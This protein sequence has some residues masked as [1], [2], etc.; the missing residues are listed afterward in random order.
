MSADATDGRVSTNGYPM[1]ARPVGGPAAW[2]GANL[3]DR[4]DWIYA[5]KQTEVAELEAAVAATE[6]K[7]LDTLAITKDDFALPTL[8][9]R[10]RD[11]RQDLLAGRGFAYLRGLPVERFDRATLARIYFGVGQHVGD[12]VPQ[13]RNGHMVAH[14]IDVG[15]DPG[16]AT[17]RLTQTPAP[18]EFH[19]DSADVAVLLCIQPAKSGGLSSIVSSTAVHDA[20]LA[21]RPDLLEVLYEPLHIDRRGEVPEG[22][23]PWYDMPTF[24]WHQGQLSTFGPLR[25]YV[26]SAQRYDGVPPLSTL[27]QDALELLDRLTSSSEFRLDLPFQVGDMQFLHNHL[28]LHGRTEYEDWPEPEKKRHLMRLWLSMPDGRALP[29]T[30]RERYTVIEL[31]QRRGGI[32]VPGLEQILPLEPDTPAYH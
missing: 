1:P 8:G 15:D 7:G 5:L 14:V 25:A 20:I 11:L 23:N 29:E 24:H 4:D 22:C 32:H 10:L 26:N 28:I 18:L 9:P 16:D 13:N 27:Q 3:A 2:R 17:K 19:S 21:E 12:P 6:A 31:G 30:F